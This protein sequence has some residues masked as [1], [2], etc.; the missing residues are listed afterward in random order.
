MSGEQLSL[1]DPRA[2][3]EPEP[4]AVKAE[5]HAT[6]PDD[7]LTPA[8][9]APVDLSATSTLI[10]ASQA[11]R[12][13]MLRQGFSENTIKAFQADL[14]L[15][16]RHMGENRA[17]GKIAQ[18]DLEEFMTWLRTERGVPCSPKSYARRLTTLKVFFGWLSAAEVLDRDPAAPLIH[19]HPTTP[20]PEVLSDEQ[21]SSLLAATRDLLWAAKPDA[22][23]FLLITILLQTGIKKGECMEIKLEHIDLSSI[24][25]PVLFVRYED[26]RKILK[27]RRLGLGPTFAPA[28]RQY[29]REYQPKERL[30]ACTARNLEYVLEEAAMLAEIAGGCSFEQLRWTCVVRDYRNGMPA[31][32]LRQK[33]G[34]SMITW[35]ETLPKI[36]KLARPAL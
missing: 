28:Y 19:V 21:T 12:G 25:S 17:I 5:P 26:P 35:R 20:L 29:L 11:F 34:L 10:D 13:H 24:Q 30:F 15:F 36:Q 22:R 32:Q 14:R 9:V 6:T 7:G 16:A 18:S 2:E 33:M 4:H 23:P 31:D 3:E 8:A 1:F 27:E